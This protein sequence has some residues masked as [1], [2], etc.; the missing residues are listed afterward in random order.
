MPR[1]SLDFPHLLSQDEV[2][3]RLRDKFAAAIAEHQDRVSDFRQEWQDHTFLFAFRTLGMAVSG[4][5]AVEP[6]RVRLAA[7]LPL[8]AMFFKRAIEDQLR[9]EMDNILS[10]KDTSDGQA[11]AASAT[12]TV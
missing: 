7:N 1:L 5:V 6:A 8:A 12:E 2:L 9:R 3:Q 11:A 4:T 10:A